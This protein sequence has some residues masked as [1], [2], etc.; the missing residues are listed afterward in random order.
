MSNFLLILKLADITP[1]YKKDSRYEKSNYQPI[2]VVP[3]LSK[4]FGNVRYD[5]II[6]LL[7]KFSLNIKLVSGQALVR[8]VAMTEK[9][10]QITRPRR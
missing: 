3:N 1:V 4:I 7:K 6:L 10:E 2:S 8:K 5:Q 9:N